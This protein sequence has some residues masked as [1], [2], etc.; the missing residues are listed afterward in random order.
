MRARLTMEPMFRGVE[1]QLPEQVLSGKGRRPRVGP[2]V[3]LERLGRGGMGH[4][5][6]AEHC[7]MKR[8]IAL[9]LAGRLRRG[10]DDAAMLNRFRREVEAAGRLRHPNIV[11]AYDAGV[12]HGRLYLAMEYIEGIDLKRLV[13]KI[14]PLTVDLACEIVRQTAE[15]LHHAHERGLVHR[16]IK[17]SNL[18]LAPPGVTVKLLD[19]G[20]A[21]LTD[22]ASSSAEEHEPDEELCGTPDFMAPE[23]GHTPCQA[24]VRGDLYSLG[25]TFYFLLTGQVPYP[26]GSWTEKLL[27]HSLDQPAP[28]RHL[29]PDVPAAVAAIVERLMA[30]EVEKRYANA[31][32]V[33]TDLAALSFAPLP[34]QKE[35]RT[36]ESKAIPRPRRAARFSCFALVAILLGVAAAGG[37]RWMVATPSMPP[38]PQPAAS[39][40]PFTIEGRPEGFDSL[41]KAIAAA[42]DGDVLTI[43]GPGP[44]M[45]PPITWEGKALTLRAASETPPRLVLKPGDDPWQALLQTDRALTLEGLDL[46]VGQESS[47]MHQGAAAPL[48]RCTQAPLYL[49]NC[50]LTTRADGV[51][52]VGRKPSEVVVRG[53]KIEAGAVGLSIEV[54][55]GSVLQ[56]RIEDTRLTV[57]EESGAAL[58]LWAAEAQQ[59]SPVELELEGCTIQAGRI[60]ALRALPPMRTITA[61]D[62][63]FRYRSALLSYSGCAQ[64]DA[65]RGTVWKG[66]GNSF[67]GPS[68]WLWVEGKPIDLRELPPTR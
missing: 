66:S 37:A 64:R 13:E 67:Q 4:V 47:R 49:T 35:E 61:R 68:S 34:I 1:E 40:Q 17:P 18:M 33:A 16:D 26:G 7:L 39:K 48:I 63:H 23:W 29:R 3:L 65:W 44:F 46:A 51:A 57:H 52:I 24:D 38:R 36:S 6:K 12:S 41:A 25:C 8:I 10:R 30:R 54:G 56:V 20:L 43:H 59:A 32:A 62:N 14:G 22:L 15:A 28:L 11:T 50:R 45:T 60:A 19:L 53:C 5:Y 58:S 21:Q 27:R 31:A 42:K 55:Q 9:K 2:Y